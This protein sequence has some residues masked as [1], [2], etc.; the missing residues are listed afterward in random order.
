[1]IR[2]AAGQVVIVAL[3]VLASPAT[4][5]T[6]SVDPAPARGAYLQI[7]SI[8]VG[9]GERWMLYLD[10]MIEPGAD[11]R[12]ARFVDQQG[13]AQADVYFN[14]PGGSLLAGMAIGRFLRER[15]FDTHVGTRTLDAGRPADGVCYSACPFAYAGGV[16]RSL[17][18]G[19]LLGVH[20]ARNR[21]PVADDGAFERLVQAD[22]T[23]YLVG[24]SVSPDLVEFMQGVPPGGIRVLTR[25]EATGF[26]LVNA[27]VAGGR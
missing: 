19:S 16:Q 1:M 14:S 24:M 26:R 18:E 8:R 7:E 25:D 17:R 15:G 20:R 22:A 6:M 11:R 23:R 4:A 2:N 10:G 9:S 13:I 5:E 3:S 21:V 27:G 12:L